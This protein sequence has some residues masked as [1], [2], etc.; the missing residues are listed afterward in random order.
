MNLDPS[1]FNLGVQ[2]SQNNAGSGSNPFDNFGGGPSIGANNKNN[3]VG[4]H[5][6]FANANPSSSSNNDFGDLFN[7]DWLKGSGGGIKRKMDSNQYAYNP[8]DLNSMNTNK[9]SQP[10]VGNYSQP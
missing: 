1:K 4:F 3:S 9:L 7:K 5:D 8:V 6:T 2:S 10:S